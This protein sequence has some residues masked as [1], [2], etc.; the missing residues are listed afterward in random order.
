[1]AH[2]PLGPDIKAAWIM[3]KEPWHAHHRYIFAVHQ[4]AWAQE[5]SKQNEDYF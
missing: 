2:F 1:M 4:A 3:A 5:Q